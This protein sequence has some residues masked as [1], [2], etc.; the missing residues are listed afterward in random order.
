MD[1]TDA[2]FEEARHRANAAGVSVDLRLGDAEALPVEDGSFDLVLSSFAAIFAPRHD[3]VTSE[4]VRVC[5]DGG[6]IAI[7]AWTPDG[8]SN[9]VVSPLI[10]SLPP[11]PDYASPSIMWGDPDHVR[12]L[13]AAYD[14]TLHFERLAFPVNFR[15]VGAFESFLFE[16]SGLLMAARR[17]L[18]ELGRW[19]Q[20]HHAMAE[21]IDQTNE[22]DDGSYRVNWDFLLTVATKAA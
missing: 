22:A 8:A 10:E 6:T 2:W 4:L 7:T 1:I 9:I 13:F 3:V 16:N 15:D 12:A 11:P 20:A 5:R 19:D 17:R 18:K 21:A 14:V